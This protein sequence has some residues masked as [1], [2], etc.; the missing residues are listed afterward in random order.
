MEGK[1]N[2]MPWRVGEE[3]EEEDLEAGFIEKKTVLH[4]FFLDLLI[5]K[6]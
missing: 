1:L 3:I 4:D 2:K 5:F 6:E